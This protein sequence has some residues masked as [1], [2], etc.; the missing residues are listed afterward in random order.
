MEIGDRVIINTRKHKFNG[1]E[2]TILD[3][4]EPEEDALIPGS[5]GVLVKVGWERPMWMRNTSLDNID[6]PAISADD[7]DID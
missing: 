3:I 5:F 7:W 4:D 2:G 1:R 6:R